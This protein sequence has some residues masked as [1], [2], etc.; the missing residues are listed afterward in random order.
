MT[1]CLKAIAWLERLKNYEKVGIPARAGTANSP[2]WN[3]QQMRSL[4]THMLHPQK[5]LKNV[6]HV[7]GTKGKGSVACMLD[8][9][10]T[11]AG[12]LVGRYSSP[13]LSCAGERISVGEQR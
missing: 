5:K 13:H 4:L 7:V 8:S 9:I 10:L 1:S 3:L 11:S 6:I 12:Y 2:T